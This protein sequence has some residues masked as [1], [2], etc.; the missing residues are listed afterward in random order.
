V[1]AT[2]EIV[3]TAMARD[4]SETTVTAG[5]AAMTGESQI[6]GSAIATPTVDARVPRLAAAT[7]H[8]TEETVATV[9]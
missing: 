4:A 1:T 2:A 9:V 6:G 8:E 3:E 7:D 5:T